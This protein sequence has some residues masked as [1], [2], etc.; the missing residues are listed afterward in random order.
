MWH[1]HFEWKILHLQ[2]RTCYTLC[3][4]NG[5]R[6]EKAIVFAWCWHKRDNCRFVTLKYDPLVYIL[7]SF[8]FTYLLV[9]L[10]DLRMDDE[11]YFAKQ[12]LCVELR[13]IY[14]RC[15]EVE[16][17]FLCPWKY[18]GPFVSYSIAKH[19]KRV[20]DIE[21]FMT[22]LIRKYFAGRCTLFEIW[23]IVLF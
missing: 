4:R 15:V 17:K 12:I 18:R 22:A 9:Q 10:V 13:V 6:R 19:C 5:K 14:T 8:G 21:H 20:Y 23:S 1:H 3:Q 16:C 7:Q 11:F 2:Y